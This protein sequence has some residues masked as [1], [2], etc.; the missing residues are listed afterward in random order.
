LGI[1]LSSNLQDESESIDDLVTELIALL[2]FSLRLDFLAILLWNW[3]V[4]FVLHDESQELNDV[5]FYTLVEADC[6]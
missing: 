4:S 6:S 5:S 2:S 3:Q 1:F